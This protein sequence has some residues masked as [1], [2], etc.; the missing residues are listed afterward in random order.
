MKWGRAV[1]HF[2]M[3]TTAVACV[4]PLLSLIVLAFSAQWPFPHLLPSL[5][6]ADHLAKLLLSP[7]LGEAVTTSLAL[8]LL[9]TVATLLL[10][11]PAA[12][13]AGL[14]SFR[15]REALKLLALMPVMVPAATV[16]MGL[17]YFMIRVGLAGTM[18][19]VVIVHTVFAVPYAFRILM[20]VFEIMGEQHEEQAAMLGAGPL[21]VFSAVTLP[22]VMPGMVAAAT[23]SFVI[24]FS[25]YIT[26][27][28]IGGGRLLTVPLLLVPH[29]QGGELHV[30][31][32]YSL[33]FIFTALAAL[34]LLRAVVRHC[35]RETYF[36]NP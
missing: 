8:A 11:F 35:Y 31:S 18:L 22:L 23:M 27:F 26:T 28:I 4:S 24:S 30:A 7:R 32:V 3:W 20:Y 1:G 9:T 2:V 5:F 34:V 6:T 13:A 10:V 12:K 15:G 36:L 19:G 17:H 33:V 21:M 29:V 14:Y 16:T 25:Q